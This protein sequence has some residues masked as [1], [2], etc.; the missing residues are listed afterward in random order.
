[1]KVLLLNPPRSWANRILDL[2]PL[3]AQRFIHRKL[4]GPPLGLLAVATAAQ[5]EHDVVLF[6]LKGEYDL[7]PD[8]QRRQEEHPPAEIVRALM[9]EHRP[10][11]VGVT[12]IASEFDAAMEMLRVAKA[13]DP[14]VLTVAGG[15][16]ATLA[17]EHFDPHPVDVL[18]TGEGVRAFS[19]LLA[20]R[21][22]GQSGPGAGRFGGLGPQTLDE[23]GGIRIRDAE[24][25]A[26]ESRLFHGPPD[27]LRPSR[28][29]AGDR[30][31][32]GRDFVRPD[33]SLLARWTPTYLVGG[34]PRPITYLYTSLG[35][36][37]R[38]TFCSIWPQH[39]GN[40]H[41]RDPDDVVDEL[42]TL[43]DYG[44]VRFADA[45]TAGDLGRAEALFDRI[46][47]SGVRQDL[48]I[49]LRMDTAAAHPAL[50]EKMARAGVKIAIAGFESP[51]AAELERYR[52]KLT[53]R[54][55]DEGFRVCEANGIRLR[56]N[57]V[58]NPDYDRDDFRVLAQFAGEHRAAYAGYTILTPLPG[59]SL[60]RQERARIVD[61][62]LA[63][64]N[65]FNCV[66]PTRLPE[67][68]FYEEVGRLWLVRE[69]T[70]TIS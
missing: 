12:T 62:D 29:P 3:E 31:P 37:A 57:Y 68:E 70:H 36:P 60:H 21:A 44:A 18:V 6:D 46:L 28:T 15:A 17:P 48:V 43:G 20:A 50:V 49:D 1:M 26:R 69:G 11:V 67:D 34:N 9:A 8:A 7:A 52:K 63:K 58:V 42:R 10:D 51:R 40:F 25:Q 38:C 66:L 64:Y 35:C 32:T 54:D 5:R 27:R 59:T 61:H 16:H 19:E 65:F 41:Q 22:A 47:Q 2:A 14:A 56:A 39:L 45:D 4:V 24:G 55:L 23:V 30:D 13:V 53:P 33:R